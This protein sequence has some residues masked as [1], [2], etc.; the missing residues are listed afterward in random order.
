MDTNDLKCFV[1]VYEEKSINQAAQRLYI[2]SQGLSK[3]IINMENDL[4]VSLFERSKKGVIPTESAEFLYER[5]IHLIGQVEEIEYGIRQIGMK[6]MK[7]RIACARGVL[8]AISFQVILDFIKKN[9]QLEVEW[10]EYSNEDVKKMVCSYKAD[11]GIVVSKSEQEQLVEK[12]IA[13]RDV[14]LLVYEGHPYYNREEISITELSRDKIIILNEQFQVYHTFYSRCMEAGF[15]PH[16]V[17]KTM[18]INFLYKLCRLKAG[19]GVIVDFSTA[20]FNLSGVKVIKLSEGLKWDI[21]QICHQQ[22]QTY[23]VI[24]AFQ[25]YLEKKVAAY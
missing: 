22:S 8:N 6:D 23:P 13:G 11:V 3:I 14:K 7:I 5:S 15:E 25:R 20:D 19:I 10:G 9:P 17:G 4:G 12:W 18:D 1:A 2:S 16:I 24:K 21:Y